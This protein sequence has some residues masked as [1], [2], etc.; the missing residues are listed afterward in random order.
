[1]LKPVNRHILI[2]VPEIPIAAEYVIVLPEDNSTPE[3]KV[4]EV[5]AR[6]TADDVRFSVPP[7]ARLV[8]DRS[9]MEEISVDGTIYNVILDNYVIGMI[10]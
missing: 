5:L 3:E 4:I 10:E 9:M 7:F 8:I 2:E 6:A 1:M